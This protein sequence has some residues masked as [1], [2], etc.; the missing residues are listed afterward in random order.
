MDGEAR[1]HDVERVGEGYG[2]YAGEGAAAESADGV[3]VE[4]GAGGFFKELSGVSKWT[5][6]RWFSR[7][8]CADTGLVS[9]PP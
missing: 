9:G 1:A 4:V 5:L 2:G 8:T 7:I 6:Q 3:F